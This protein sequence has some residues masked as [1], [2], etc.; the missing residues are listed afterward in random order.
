MTAKQ[1]ETVRRDLFAVKSDER[2]GAGWC[3]VFISRNRQSAHNRARDIRRNM[4][5]GLCRLAK[6]IHPTQV[7]VDM[8]CLAG[9]RID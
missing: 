1:S 6:V 9:N 7:V 3:V 5:I 2:D 8:F 4:S